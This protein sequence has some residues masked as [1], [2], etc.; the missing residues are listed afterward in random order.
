MGSVLGLKGWACVQAWGG[1]VSLCVGVEGPMAGLGSWEGG[2]PH[3]PA[4]V[5]GLQGRQ[6]VGDKLSRMDGCRGLG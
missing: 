6:G 1:R 3:S 5:L 2:N 4:G